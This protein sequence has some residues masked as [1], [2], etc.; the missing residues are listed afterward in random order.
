MMKEEV[1]VKSLDIK[2]IGE[3][4]FFQISLPHDTKKIIGIE[5][6][7]MA[8]EGVLL[9]SPTFAPSFAFGGEDDSSLD[10]FKNKTV[11]RLVLRTASCSEIFF[12]EDVVENRNP[13]LGENITAVLWSPQFWTHSRKRHEIELCVCESRMVHGI[14]ED[15]WGFDEYQTLSYTLNIYL[16]IEKCM[17]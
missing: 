15:S 7:V 16:W 17:K 5:Y 3:R 9:P 12:Q 13:H 1:I 6:G 10:F 11:G 4:Q 14:Y 8:K 2:K